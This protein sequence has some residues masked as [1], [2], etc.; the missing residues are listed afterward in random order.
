MGKDNETID[1]P[2]REIDENGNPIG[3]FSTEPIDQRK[4][5]RTEEQT[6]ERLKQL[7]QEVAQEPP[8]PTSIEV[9]RKTHE[10]Q[11]AIRKAGAAV[12]RVQRALGSANLADQALAHLENRVRGMEKQNLRRSGKIRPVK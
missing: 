6:R 10:S 12:Q 2:F 3:E 9:L 11:K 1:A 7:E 5:I 4:T 8:P